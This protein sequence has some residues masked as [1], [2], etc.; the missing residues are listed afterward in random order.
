[1]VTDQQFA[2]GTPFGGGYRPPA[3]GNSL[4]LPIVATGACHESARDGTPVVVDAF[5]G[6][7]TSQPPVGI[8]EVLE[9][10]RTVTLETSR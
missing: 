4:L 1:M 7:A 5:G 6:M 2:M 3:A 10:L 8:F 9:I